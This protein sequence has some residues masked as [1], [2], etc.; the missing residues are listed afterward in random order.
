VLDT[1]EL[2][3]LI[4]SAVP[5]EHR[6]SLRR[7]S[8]NWQVAVLKIGHVMEPFDYDWYFF[9]DQIDVS[10]GP[11]YSLEKDLDVKHHPYL[12]PVHR[13]TNQMDDS[14]DHCHYMIIHRHL[15]FEE[16]NRRK[17]EFIT[18]PPVSQVVIGA[19][20]PTH[21]AS[22]RVPGGIRM[23]GLLEHYSK[24]SGVAVLSGETASFAVRHFYDFSD[25]E[26]EGS[27]IMV[28]GATGGETDDKAVGGEVVG[29]GDGEAEVERVRQ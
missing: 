20:L 23:G 14:C 21:M 2:L 3:H 10:N 25:C 11:F 22:L 15:T 18:I 29:D 5:R 6:T 28:G 13:C 4:I 17:H 8:K 12:Y 7:V 9:D 24:M 26:S 16:V 1:N 19:D 27:I